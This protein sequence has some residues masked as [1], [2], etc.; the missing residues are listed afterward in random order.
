M[1]SHLTY[2]Q[3]LDVLKAA[4]AENSLASFIKQGWKYIDPQPYV[5]GI[6]IDAMCEHLEAVTRGE[7]KRLIINVPPGTSKSSIVSV[8]WPAWTWIQSELGHLSGPQIQFMSVSYAQTLSE[9]DSTKMRRLID[10]EWYQANWGDRFQLVGDQNTK[11]KF[12]NTENGYRLSTSVT[13]TATGDGAKIIICDD[14]L[15]AKDA[16][17]EIE[18]ANVI[19]WWTQTMPTRL[20]DAKNGA[21]VVVMQR[22]HQNDLSGYIL[23]HDTAGDWTHLM[24]PM[25]YD[26]QRH[27]ST[28]IGWEDPRTI[29]GELL[30]PGRYGEKEVAYLEREMGSY[31]TAGQLQQS[32]A[33][34][35]GGII[36]REHWQLWPPEDWKVD[37][38]KP[39]QFPPFEYILASCDTAYTEKAENDYSACTVWGVWRDKGNLPKLMLIEAWQERLEFK[40]L[41]DK[42][43]KT[44]TRRKIDCLL[45]E[46]KA[47]GQSV[48]QEV[49]RLCAT[50]DFSTYAINPGSGDKVTRVH[51]LQP[52]FE[53]GA[54]Y[55]PDRKYADMVIS[56]FEI[57]P[58]GKHDDLVDS[59]SQA[60]QYM[61]KIG[62][63][64]LSAEGARDNTAAAMHRPPSEPIYDV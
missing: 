42:I 2:Q 33:P 34:K 57:F 35:G 40:A 54:V 25:R 55:A 8:A 50:E 49:K 22:L 3:N 20:R 24:L 46:A 14:V 63:A 37:D 44:A 53:N 39:L 56:Q 4:Q 64:L 16:N 21:I 7:L 31:G 62:L 26:S 32:P 27:C 52:L 1:N 10:S 13:G 51:T 41:V 19:E 30:C 17:S 59:V 61:R 38:D 47:S 5:H 60:L 28:S 36:K 11:R 29:E 12:E 45:I 6:N 58:K 43:I 15:N 48:F 18:I 23:E 9:R